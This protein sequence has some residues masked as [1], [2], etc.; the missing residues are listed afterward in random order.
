MQKRFWASI[1]LTLSVSVSL[2]G[3]FRQK[4]INK[5]AVPAINTTATK[6]TTSSTFSSNN[7]EIEH[8]ADLPLAEDITVPEKEPAVPGKETVTSE[9][10]I[11]ITTAPTEI[12]ASETDIP[13]TESPPSDAWNGNI[14][15]QTNE[16]PGADSL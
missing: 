14:V 6:E 4:N 13:S 9:E 10:S 5:N 3:C 16:L 2:C 15:P 11:E 12:T 7:Y 1:L 8:G